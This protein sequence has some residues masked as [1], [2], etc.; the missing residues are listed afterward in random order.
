MPLRAEWALPQDAGRRYAALSGDWNPIHLWGW[1]ARLFG[2]R[3]P[4]IHGAHSMARA[5]AELERLGGR[6]LQTL[7]LDPAARAAGQHTRSACGPGRTALR[8]ARGRPARRPAPGT[9]EGRTRY[10]AG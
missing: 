3:Q 4:I 6:P 10:R 2:L 1:S 8:A 7:A 9:T 5:R